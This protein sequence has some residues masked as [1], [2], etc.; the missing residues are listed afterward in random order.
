[1]RAAIDWVENHPV[2]KERHVQLVAALVDEMRLAE[3]TSDLRPWFNRL[4]E[5]N[6]ELDRTHGRIPTVD[7]WPGDMDL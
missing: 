6:D 2:S 1:M 3:D 4:F 7:D 5:I